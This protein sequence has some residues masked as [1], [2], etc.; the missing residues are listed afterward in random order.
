MSADEQLADAIGNLADVAEH[1]R[2]DRA[3]E[4]REARYT[5]P[6]LVAEFESKRRPLRKM[7]F[8]AFVRNIPDIAEAF[9]VKVPS[10]FWTDFEGRV[11]VPC[12]CKGATIH[13]TQWPAPCPAADRTG[14]PR[15]YL[16]DG[17]NVRVAFSP[18]GG[19]PTPQPD[20]I[21]H[22]SAD[23]LPIG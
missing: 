15:W 14:C 19:A 5:D 2:Q 1:F 23:D 4:R 20:E 11:E 9:R 17:E 3:A 8:G 6:E 7:P 18:K 16:Y 21:E 13:P 12:P 22:P 10:N